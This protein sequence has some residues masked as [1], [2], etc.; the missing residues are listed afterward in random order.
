[1]H[2][3]YADSFKGLCIGFDWEK[4]E[5]EFHGTWVQNRPRKVKYRPNPPLITER[6]GDPDAWLTVFTTKSIDF[7]SESEWRMFYKEGVWQSNKVKNS[8]KS[9]T[10]GHNCIKH[11]K[12]TEKLKN[13]I[14]WTSDSDICESKVRNR[15]GL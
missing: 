3:L 12:W 9:I 1:M 15:I 6:M 8:I 7:S 4:F 10:F 14:D 5:L 13:I 11:E 2:A